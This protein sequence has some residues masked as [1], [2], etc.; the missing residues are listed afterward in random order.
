MEEHAFLRAFD[1]GSRL[2]GIL[3]PKRKLFPEGS[4]RKMSKKKRA[5]SLILCFVMVFSLLTVIPATSVTPEA[6]AAVSGSSVTVPN[7]WSARKG[8]SAGNTYGIGYP[9]NSTTARMLT[10]S[11]NNVGYKDIAVTRGSL[12]LPYFVASDIGANAKWTTSYDGGWYWRN[13]SN[14]Y[15]LC[16][17]YTGAGTGLHD[18]FKITGQSSQPKNSGTLSGWYTFK[19]VQTVNANS[20]L[21]RVYYGGDASDKVLSWYAA[22]G[23]WTAINTDGAYKD[24]ATNTNIFQKQDLNASIAIVGASNAIS[25]GTIQYKYQLTDD[26]GGVSHTAT[27]TSLLSSFPGYT[28]GTERGVSWS[29]KNTDVATIDK[30][31]GEVRAVG[32][33]TTTITC[34]FNWT[35]AGT[36]YTLT[37]SKTLTVKKPD[38]KPS[39]PGGAVVIGDDDDEIVWVATINEQADKNYIIA[40]SENNVNS[41]ATGHAITDNGLNKRPISTDVT[42][43]RGAAGA[44]YIRFS[45][46]PASNIQWKLSGNNDDYRWKSVNG[47]LGWYYESLAVNNDKVQVRDSVRTSVGSL[48]TYKW[49][50]F[51]YTTGKDSS[52]Y[53]MF[54]Q[55]KGTSNIDKYL[56][57]NGTW[58][59]DNGSD[60]SNTNERKL[61]LFTPGTISVSLHISPASASGISGVGGQSFKYSISQNYRYNGGGNVMWVSDN[62]GVAS[63]DDN[64]NVTYLSP[65]TANISCWYYWTDEI[66]GKLYAIYD[67]AQVTVNE[68]CTLSYDAN[69]GSGSMASQTV[70]K[71]GSVT[72]ASN[73]FTGPDSDAK[74]V[75]WSTSP[76]GDIYSGSTMKL[77]SDTTLYAIWGYEVT[78]RSNDYLKETDGHSYT[79]VIRAD[80]RGTVVSN[81]EFYSNGSGSIN[82]VASD[83]IG[84]SSKRSG[85]PEIPANTGK[86]TL[87]GPTILYAQWKYDNT[88]NAV[89]D[90][91]TYPIY[92]TCIETI[93]GNYPTEP[94]VASGYNWNSVVKSAEGAIS[95]SVGVVQYADKAGS[96]VRSDIFS[97]PAFMHSNNEG[98][99]WGVAFASVEGVSYEPIQYIN[100]DPANG[101]VD[102][103]AIKVAFLSDSSRGYNIP[104]SDYD[105]YELIPYVVKLQHG[106]SAGWHVDCYLHLKDNVRYSYDVGLDRAQF[107]IK[108]AMPNGGNVLKNQTLENVPAYPSDVEV[109]DSYGE[110]VTFLGYQCSNG[111]YYEWNAA[112]QKFVDPD[113]PTGTSFISGF[114]FEEDTLF[115][116]V[117]KT[118]P[119]S[120]ILTKT[121]E[122]ASGS[123]YDADSG[124][125]FDLNI[126]LD[127]NNLDYEEIPYAVYNS[128]N[129]LVY[130]DTIKV[131]ADNQHN[132]NI[133]VQLGNGYRVVV[134]QITIDSTY[135]ITET[136]AEGYTLSAGGNVGLSGTFEGGP[137]TVRAVNTYNKE[138]VLTASTAVIDFG[139]PVSVDVKYDVKGISASPLSSGSSLSTADVKLKSGTGSAS[140]STLTYT[141]TYDPQKEQNIL[142]EKDTLYYAAQPAKHMRYSQLD[143]IPAADVYYE[144]SFVSYEGK[145][146]SV[147]EGYNGEAK[148]HS[149]D[150]N[151][152]YGYDETYGKYTEYSLGTAKQ[153]TV[154]GDETAKASFTFTGTGFEIYSACTA[155]QGGAVI[156]VYNK[157][158]QRVGMKKL[159][160]TVSSG[161]YWQTPIYMQNL[162]Y[163]TYRVDIEVAY[164]GA[165]DPIRAD[166]NRSGSVT[167]I[168]DGV[169]IYNTNGTFNNKY[170]ADEQNVQFI[171][172]RDKLI[173]KKSFDE[174]TTGGAVFIDGR[175]VENEDK[176]YTYE[177]DIT[178]NN[179]SDYKNFGPKNEVYL[180]KGQAV[181]FR[182]DKYSGESLQLGMKAANLNASTVT[183]NGEKITLAGS[184]A[185]YYKIPSNGGTVV[186]VNSGEG[187]VS[188]TNLKISGAGI[189][190]AAVPRGLSVDNDVVS[191]AASVMMAIREEPAPSEE[192]QP[193]EE[194]TPT[195]EP[196]PTEE[197]DPAPTDEPDEGDDDDGG[198]TVTVWEKLINAAKRL[199]ETIWSFVSKLFGR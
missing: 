154:K 109:Y 107:S 50:S 13:V 52:T 188:I 74:F 156:S 187:L 98:G 184:T 35:E 180:A 62:P 176:T 24:K 191:Y 177:K 44:P 144:D 3:I 54:I 38:V 5:L 86:L 88:G 27:G 11:G 174:G 85:E 111:K 26:L 105:K 104:E 37:T 117:W 181:A 127:L 137:K 10:L 124:K 165:L 84:W 128:S 119:A 160:A 153:V 65:G 170:A 90:S 120:L 106:T 51:D 157:D 126:K 73:S 193:T 16:F 69:G 163:G 40:H 72:I 116:A 20:A 1:C 115:T 194:P 173:T 172:V 29:S 179:V 15:Y 195:E 182:V 87:S 91:D 139:L 18:T 4:L 108:G 199:N 171:S 196:E 168:L 186:I 130:G 77:N 145:W 178:T 149:G 12:G 58:Y 110:P 159:V 125:L 60:S 141:P 28:Y 129:E 64:G 2:S 192:P 8:V 49:C 48:E 46:N 33:G 47:Y 36:Q 132:V 136:A 22:G 147:G 76:N 43:Q 101:G 31:S 94:M 112:A 41:K 158:N 63:V 89:L 103:E 135:A 6:S 118:N 123:D 71:G 152:V 140:G 150:K 19:N 148:I 83:I 92:I 21:T 121:V 189:D 9:L 113:D 42:V 80:G 30:D 59:R 53:R 70:A 96:I 39:A 151:D 162:D 81:S 32:A 143:I 25:G 197:P 56:T 190:T 66:N 75:G 146:T 134:K 17:N 99:T 23:Y 102:W 93:D 68:S 155:Q 78:F 133:P 161:D 122:T 95:A 55:Y 79:K 57:Y 166:G 175:I 67:T 45:A 131:T 97:S 169:R 14:N 185:M 100:T 167:F 34:T 183:V 138:T 142:G 198:K 61:T 114:T 82:T 7:V 164:S